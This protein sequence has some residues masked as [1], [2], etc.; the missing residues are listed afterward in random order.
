MTTNTKAHTDIKILP[1]IEK[2][3]PAAMR[4]YAYLMRLDRPIG[5]WLLLLPSFWGIALA[6]S[7]SHGLTFS[8]YRIIILFTLGAIIMR[9]AGC[10]IN[11]LWDRDLDKMVER[12]KDRP[13]AN[14]TISI[15]KGVVFLATL[16]LIGLIIL[17]QFNTI[18]IILGVITL[19]LIMSYPLMKR[20]TWWP[21]AFL[22]LTFNFGALMGYSALTGQITLSSAL[23]YLGGIFW[24]LGYDTIYAHQDKEDDLMAGIKSTALK[25]GENSKKWVGMF[26]AFSVVSICSAQIITNGAS[27]T[28]SIILIPMFHFAW[29]IWMWKPSIQ[30]SSLTIFKSNQITGLLILFILSL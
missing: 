26:Y 23:L 8:D 24:T 12:T 20:F 17:L 13:L 7:Q 27:I 5:I 3:L 2:H 4:P 30:A 22:G 11:D 14:G 29:Q 9:G 6:N 21:Q 18:T 10:V 19:P 28:S 15:K 16:L 1:W 25:F